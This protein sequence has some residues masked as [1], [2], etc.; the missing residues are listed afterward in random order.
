MK[1]ISFIKKLFKKNKSHLCPVC[2]KHYFSKTNSYEI[3]PICGWE[4]N[5][6]QS[7]DPDYKGGPNSLSLN[8]AIKEYEDK[9][10]A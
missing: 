3:C 7:D 1:F 4:D 10:D 6:V 8:E 5:R 2:K 9:K